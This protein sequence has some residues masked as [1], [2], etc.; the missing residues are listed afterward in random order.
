MQRVRLP[1][2]AQRFNEM[3]GD[4]LLRRIASFL[5]LGETLTS[6][7]TFLKLQSAFRNRFSLR[8]RQTYERIL[9]DKRTQSILVRLA[10]LIR[11]SDRITKSDS[12]LRQEK[13]EICVAPRT[14]KSS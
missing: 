10:K 14:G 2:W 11:V 5:S 12:N 6:F 4:F 1:R 9:R 8:A 7:P 3:V 13:V